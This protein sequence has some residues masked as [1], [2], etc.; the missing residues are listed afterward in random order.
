[1]MILSPTNVF[2]A[3]FAAG[4]IMM[5]TSALWAGLLRMGWALPLSSLTL[6][7]IHGQLFVGGMLGTVIGLERAVAIGRPWAF[8]GPLLTLLGGISLL[9]GLPAIIGA[10]LITGGS[11]GLLAIFALL[12]KRQ[13]VRFVVTMALGGM[14]WFGGNLLWLMG[15]P[16][17]LASLWW[18]SFLTLTI[19]GERL[20]LGRLRHLPAYTF[21][22][23]SLSVG[24]LWLGLGWSLAD[25]ANGT[26]LAG[27]GLLASGLWLLAYDIGRR[28][29]RRPGLPRFSATCMLS[30][31]A[32]LTIGGLL[33]AL[34]GGVYGG[35][36][37][38]AILHSI[39]VGF[40]FAMIF[41]HALII[42]PALLSVPVRFS[43]WSYLP[44]GLLH[45]S[46]ALR[47]IG[48]LCM[49]IEFRRWGGMMNAV[50]IIVFLMITATSIVRAHRQASPATMPL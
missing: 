7:A 9:M 15:Q 10:L 42:I 12:L 41:G 3:G 14:A 25:Y 6:A 38:D 44:L 11:V 28:T 24:L 17:A 35:L 33:M 32:W 49:L 26:R 34:S 29:I 21:W 27:I 4:V 19:F 5:L 43:G 2:R 36:L 47:V 16:L 39:F 20:E 46:L 45:V 50:S 13:P 30:G 40:V 22:S 48:D 31:S 23:F 8:A 37:Y 18:A 1:M